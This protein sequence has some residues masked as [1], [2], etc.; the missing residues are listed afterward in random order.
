VIAAGAP[1]REDPGGYHWD[2]PGSPRQD[3]GPGREDP[4]GCPPCTGSF[5]CSLAG[6]EASVQAQTNADGSCTLSGN[7]ANITL[8]CQGVLLEAGQPVGTWAGDGQGG[9]SIT[10]G[11]DAGSVTFACV[12]SSGS[13]APSPSPSS[14][15]GSLDN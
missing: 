2:N 11:T 13:A 9:F 8:D 15:A 6:I 4:N 12:P 1:G 5:D 3:P 7:G 14:D 10:Q